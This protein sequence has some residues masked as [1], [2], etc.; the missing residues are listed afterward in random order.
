MILLAI[1]MM[2]VPI[3]YSLYKGWEAYKQITAPGDYFLFPKG[4]ISSKLRDSI[5]ASN[6]SLG[7]AIFAFLSFGF[8]FKVA[9]IISPITWLA[10]FVILI[11]VFHRITGLS[12]GRTLHGYLAFRYDSV[13][14][15]Y[16]ASIA[17]IVG[18]LGTYGVEV[19]VAIKLFRV[20]V[21]HDVSD[22]V[23]AISLSFIVTTYT[24]L[25]G[26][27]AASHA[28]TFRLRG[29]VLGI[30]V[31]FFYSLYIAYTSPTFQQTWLPESISSDFFG[32][33]SLTILFVASLSLLNVPWQLVDMSV[34]QRLVACKGKED[35]KKGL[36]QSVAFI[37][38]LWLVLILLGMLLHYFPGF[39]APDNGDFATPFLSYLRNPLI[40]A[41]FAAGCVAALMSTADSLLIA[42]VQTLVMDVFFPHKSPDLLFA[43]A[44][45]EADQDFSEKLLSTGR[46]WA[47]VL[48]ISSPI[49]IYLVN[50]VIPGILDLFFLIYTAQLT[51]LASVLVAIY[52]HNPTRYKWLAAASIVLG[53]IT[54]F[55]MFVKMLLSPSMETFLWAPLASVAV[56][57]IPWV[58][59][60]LALKR[61][62]ASV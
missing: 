15:G 18:F 58:L 39:A 57:L 37:A 19:L 55:T 23:L 6:V 48:G 33:S 12:S 4:F 26:F 54:A 32:F 42:S 36:R 10:G 51:L 29:T 13:G 50:V 27:K 22:I 9:A 28:D 31:A 1:L 40:F 14:I 21:P 17:S 25:G 61:K 34:W 59:F 45:T 43:K 52:S 41:L 5:T 47:W 53:L 46:K 35:I 62:E 38:V 49:L 20:I 8:S 3:G 56:S 30:A 24:A 7:S 60:L 2:L 11:Y 44:S 16:L